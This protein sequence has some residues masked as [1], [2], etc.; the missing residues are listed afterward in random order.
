MAEGP[1]WFFSN[2]CS[3]V[4]LNVRYLPS[5]RPIRPDIKPRGTDDDPTGV[6]RDTPTPVSRSYF[7][8]VHS[9]VAV[10]RKRL[11]SRQAS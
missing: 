2:A 11:R 3:S 8:I 7:L 10:S 9:A 4:P 6:K 1:L 5:T